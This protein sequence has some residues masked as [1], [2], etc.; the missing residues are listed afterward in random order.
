MEKLFQPVTKTI[1]DIPVEVTKTITETSNKKIQ[2]I[3]KFKQQ[4]SRKIE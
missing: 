2:N 1:K 3:R 4:T